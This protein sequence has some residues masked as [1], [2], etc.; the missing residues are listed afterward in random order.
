MSYPHYFH[1]TDRTTQSDNI[2]TEHRGAAHLY[3]GT[4]RTVGSTPAHLYGRNSPKEDRIAIWPI[5]RSL[6]WPLLIHRPSQKI[7]I[8]DHFNSNT[9]SWISPTPMPPTRSVTSAIATNIKHS[10]EDPSS[11]ISISFSIIFNQSCQICA[12]AYIA[13]S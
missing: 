13:R 11:H 10:D 3:S 5:L 8:F 9:P 1:F 2:H 12:Q 4:L 6:P 7:Y